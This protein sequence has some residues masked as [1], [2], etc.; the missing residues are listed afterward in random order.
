MS[1]QV[2]LEGEFNITQ[3][4]QRMQVLAKEAKDT[5]QDLKTM[6]QT[7]PEAK[8]LVADMNKVGAAMKQI[9]KD[10]KGAG[11]ET[12][13]FT[14]EVGN[15][16]RMMAYNTMTLM[17]LSN[18]I[19]DFAVAG[20]RGAANNMTFLFQTFGNNIQAAGG[21]KN[22][23]LSAG[24]AMFMPPVG[25]IF[26]LQMAVTALDIFTSNMGKSERK[27]NDLSLATLEI[28]NS[29]NSWNKAV[30]E[31]QKE[32]EKLTES[33]IIDFIRDVNI[34]INN[35]SSAMAKALANQAA[36]S[37]SGGGG[38]M[39][40]WFLTT[41]GINEDPEELAEKMKKLNAQKKELEGKLGGQRGL[42]EGMNARIK[43][44]QDLRETAKTEAEI[45]Q[46]NKML[47]AEQE[48]RDRLLG[49]SQKTKEKNLITTDAEL[50]AE[51]ASLQVELAKTSSVRERYILME[52]LRKV[53][54]ELNRGNERL[55]GK[56]IYEPLANRWKQKGEMQQLTGGNVPGREKPAREEWSESGAILQVT[57]LRELESQARKTGQTMFSSFTMAL[58][59]FKDAH[60]IF[61]ILI[62]DLMQ[63][64]LR[65]LLISGI[66]M[67]G[68]G[69]LL[70]LIGLG[71]GGGA[72]ASIST[73]SMA[74]AS[75]SISYMPKVNGLQTIK[76]EG[77][78][79]QKGRDL[80][81]ILKREQ[82][83]ITRNM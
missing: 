49:K 78:F 10:Y 48:K 33:E 50:Q 30:R 42:L 8:Q 16:D 62:N 46:Y 57:A 23:L 54:E 36:A 61:E 56:S 65:I 60:N 66:K 34:E 26:G 18:G 47:N 14:K 74:N 21:F 51:R 58:R 68:G 29:T 25:I 72:N 24:K 7:S 3:I 32:V 64:G 81:M 79:T 52:K 59:P 4:L 43:E 15:A 67:I 82:R 19:Q 39:L 35:T 6:M 75:K 17:S 9:N 22:A 55:Y 2:Y 63:M 31:L 73:A 37:A 44:L 12:K 27:A 69:G 83:F 41:I 5:G 1:D 77:E 13:Q 38:K 20:V 28:T 45:L 80:S 53:E 70:N 40:N 76:L 71:G 11:V